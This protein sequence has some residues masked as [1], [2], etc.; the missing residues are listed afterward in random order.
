[1]VRIDH[2]RIISRRLLRHLMPDGVQESEK[3]VGLSKSL[4]VYRDYT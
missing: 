1:M 2:T 4:I 3:F